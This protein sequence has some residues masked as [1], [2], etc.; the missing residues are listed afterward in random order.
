MKKIKLL[1]IGLLSSISLVTLIDFTLFTSQQKET[2]ITISTK[3]QSY[4]NAGGNSHVAYAIKTPHKTFSIT[5]EFAQ[6]INEG[7]TIT[8]TLSPIFKE[9]NSYHTSISNKETYSLR[10]LTGCIL[11]IIT[12]II[13]FI[14]FKTNKTI[15][16]LL[17]VTILAT[18][19][20]TIYLI[21]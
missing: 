10:W 11:P 2:I 3:H 19:A 1:I 4:Y 12:L 9:V 7:E 14:S 15:N 16:I 20:N 13:F 8:Y 17:F 21:I 5:K 6:V 18:I